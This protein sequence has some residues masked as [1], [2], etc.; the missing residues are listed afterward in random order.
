MVEKLFCLFIQYFKSYILK[1]Y[2]RAQAKNRK[3]A[4]QRAKDANNYM[5][6]NFFIKIDSLNNNDFYSN[7]YK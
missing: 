4:I 7:T 3:N 5:G 6:Y 2:K 1:D